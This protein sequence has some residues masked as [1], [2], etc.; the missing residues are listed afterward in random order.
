MESKGTM[1]IRLWF[2]YRLV[3]LAPIEFILASVKALR[4]NVQVED[5]DE[6]VEGLVI[7]TQGFLDRESK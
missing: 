7:G 5:T 6:Y 1:K 4:W 2:I 3:R